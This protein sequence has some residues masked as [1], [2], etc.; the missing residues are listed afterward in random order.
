MA[1]NLTIIK[2]PVGTTPGEDRRTFTSKGTIGRSAKNDWVLVDPDR[3]LSS[4]HCEIT[5]DAGQ[6]YLVDLSTNGTFVNGS[7][8]P[9]GRG[10]RILLSEGDSFDVG[11]YRFKVS[12]E[13]DSASFPDSP[14]ASESPF[15]QNTEAANQDIDFAQTPNVSPESL[16]MSSEYSDGVIADIT[17]EDMKITDPLI[18]LNISSAPAKS[19]NNGDLIKGGIAGSQEDSAD[20]LH[21]AADWPQAN[22]EESVIPEDWADDISLLGS[23]KPATQAQAPAY[24]LPD[25]DSLIQKQK[26]K[27]PAPKRRSPSAP[28]PAAAPKAQPPKATS[29]MDRTLVDSLGF[30]DVELSDEKI[31]EIHG[32]VGTM[33][34]ETIDGLMQILR[35]RTSIKNEF[36]INITTIQP[37]ENNPLKFSANVDE[38]LENMF[39]KNSK[40]Y[41]KPIEAVQESF[42]TIIDHQVAVI[43]GIRSAFK[44]V[45][46]Q[47]D[48][49]I[50]EETFRDS[51]KAGVLGVMRG[52]LWSAYQD[53]YQGMADDMERS[54]QELFGD[55]FVQ[56]YEDQLQKLS[57]ARKRKSSQEL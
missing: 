24:K 40:A 29:A 53:H 45:L 14:F 5:I 21:S 41:K 36:R 48:P 55:D 56:A 17:P 52:K 2:T 43:A 34:R 32:T 54:F 19:Q 38:V 22:A 23:K 4:R 47:F 27:K 1:L 6:H 15:E 31:R 42:N 35:S 50:L 10:S 7:P 3:F 37:I 49:S 18:A 13:V 39:L 57:H 11:D 12:I 33:M 25:T 8:E 30:T 9:L 51:G 46:T 20:F 26:P 16:F 28:R 44:S